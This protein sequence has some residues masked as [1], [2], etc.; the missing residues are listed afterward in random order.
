[1][2]ITLTNS[3]INIS[4]NNILSVDGSITDKIIDDGILLGGNVVY[5]ININN[6]D[7]QLCCPLIDILPSSKVVL[8]PS[9]KLPFRKYPVYVYLY[10]AA[11]YLS[12]NKSMRT[13]AN[14]VKK[15]YGLE[16]FSH[17]TLSR[18]LKKL[19]MEVDT[20]QE[21]MPSVAE[22]CAGSIL[23]RKNWDDDQMH[24]NRQ[25]V[26]LL[27]PILDAK[28]TVKYGCMINYRYFNH[29]GRFIL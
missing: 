3:E 26:N 17:S 28:K 7:Y 13:V 21:A 5:K 20:L 24:K 8:W 6:K 9:V 10:A 29:T 11:L 19:K 25:L 14:E 22:T 12:T 1:M 23:R 4:E 27:M 2:I 15:L 16:K 18:T